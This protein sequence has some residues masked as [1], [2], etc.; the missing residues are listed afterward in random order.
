MRLAAAMDFTLPLAGYLSSSLAVAVDSG[1]R[2]VVRVSA[3]VFVE[4]RV[5]VFTHV[6]LALT[7]NEINIVLGRLLFSD[8][9]G[10]PLLSLD[11]LINVRC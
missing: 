10:D 7:S 8:I 3:C 6:R 2:T 1:S 9:V 11:F 4:L 5:S